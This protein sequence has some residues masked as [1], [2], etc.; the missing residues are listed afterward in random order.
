MGSK[1]ANDG[2]VN[3]Y[4]HQKINYFLSFNVLLAIC[5]L[6]NTFVNQLTGN[7]IS[8]E[9]FILTV[10]VIITDLIMAGLIY[11]K[12]INHKPLLIFSVAGLM[13]LVPI[14]WA[15]LSE[16]LSISF[17]WGIIS[18]VFFAMFLRKSYSIALSICLL[19]IFVYFKFS[20]LEAL[21]LGAHELFTPVVTTFV[22]VYSILFLSK[23]SLILMKD[24]SDK[25][26]AKLVG[27]YA[28]TIEHEEMLE[29]ELAQKEFELEKLRQE[30]KVLR[31]Q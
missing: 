6:I 30:V 23:L 8:A 20:Q 31:A 3:W 13:F 11:Y 21:N 1:K 4:H 26:K 2:I 25:N 9:F 14:R 24:Y 29:E 17:Y 27:A 5:A 16:K 7:G 10:A 12:H 18:C 28:D 15:L 22:T 19:V